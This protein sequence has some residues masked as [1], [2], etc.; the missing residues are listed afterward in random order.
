M[1]LKIQFALAATI[2]IVHNIHNRPQYRDIAVSDFS[3]MLEARKEILG[4]EIKKLWVYYDNHQRA[5][6]YYD[7]HNPNN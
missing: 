1:N 5:I 4:K 3:V 7:T 2:G 6:K